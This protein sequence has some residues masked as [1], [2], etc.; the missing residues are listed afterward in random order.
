MGFKIENGI[1][2]K[3]TEDDGIT[4]VTIPDG[5]ISI[6]SY[7][8]SWCTS[9]TRINISD[10]ITNIRSGVFWGCK[11][12]KEIKVSENNNKYCD[13]D[14]VLF[15]K[16]KK[17]LLIYPQGRTGD[18]SVPDSV[19]NIGDVA[20]DD[21]TSLTSVNI[22]DNISNIRCGTFCNCISL[23]G[24]N[25]PDSVT[26]I[27]SCAFLGCTNLISI[28][29]PD[30]VT[31]IGNAAF[32]NC[33][34][35]TGINVPDGVTSIGRSAFENCT[36]LKSIT[37]PDSVTS[38]RWDAFKNC[39]S[40]T[41][42]NIPDIAGIKWKNIFQ[43]CKNLISINIPEN[44]NNIDYRNFW[45]YKVLE[46]IK[47]NENNTT[48]CDIDGVIFSKDKKTLLICPKGRT[49]DYS[50]PDSVTSIGDSAF[51][52]CESLTSITIP[53]GLKIKCDEIKSANESIADT[54]DMLL[55]KDFSR[56]FSHKVKFKLIMDYFF[57]TADE[58]AEAYLKKNFLK[59]SRQFIENNDIE[60]INKILDKTN[61]VTKR[62]IE[63][64]CIHAMD[65]DM[66][67][68]YDIL[69]DYRNKNF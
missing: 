33:T 51:R 20:F 41:S 68:I 19:T 25:I 62:N 1:L 46:E 39:T 38:I 61:F 8:F 30:S 55:K 14:G 45:D 52:G 36:S 9:L 54:I 13:I 18:Y 66:Q 24:I 65:N 64:L 49:G 53:D 32:K 5:V 50:I 7:A 34:N 21:C 16:D 40:L 3:Y 17:T 29:I 4:K 12:L 22:P 43:N 69:T 35:L 11:S 48:Y 27:D 42:I 58:V 57:C 44:M 23:K 2:K 37:I 6:D 26:S 47:V 60:R 10:S 63:K 56:K 59:I 28:N 15:S 67:E 31:S